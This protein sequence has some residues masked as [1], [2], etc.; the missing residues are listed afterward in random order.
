M[1]FMNW[2]E[3]YS[4]KVKSCDLQHQKLFYLINAL[5]EAMK[6]RKGRHYAYKIVRELNQY[7]QSHFS[8]EEGL[9]E[10]T[11]YPRL[12]EQ[13]AQHQ[14]FISQ[15]KKFEQDIADGNMISISLMDFL[16]SWLTNHIT[17]MDQEYSEHLNKNGIV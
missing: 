2:N 14:E 9:L 5:Q 17:S 16:R 4:V 8:A 12:A 13:R 15:V 6:A 7:T 11:N 10:R 3:S 1:T